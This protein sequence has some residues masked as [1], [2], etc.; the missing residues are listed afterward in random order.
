VSRG[1]GLGILWLQSCLE[2]GGDPVRVEAMEL[3]QFT[4][5]SL[6]VLIYVG[7]RDGEWSSVKEIAGAYG[8]SKNHLVKVVHNLSKLGYL[9]RD[10]TRE[11]GRGNLYRDGGEENGEVFVGRVFFPLTVRLLSDRA[12]RVAVGSTEGDQVVLGRVRQSHSGRF[13]D[14]E[15][16]AM[17]TPGDRAPR[18][19]LLNPKRG[20]GDWW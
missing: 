2:S 14:E 19:T 5:F 18:E 16:R 10:C 17:A 7:V 9:G 3:S 12:L 15:A 1:W 20:T 8:I 13:R 11:T 4:D 6:R